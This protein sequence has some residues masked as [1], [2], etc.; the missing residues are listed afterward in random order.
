MPA[1]MTKCAIVKPSTAPT[2]KLIAGRGMIALLVASFQAAGRVLIHPISAAPAN[3]DVTASTLMRV[4]LR[5]TE[6]P[7]AVTPINSIYWHPCAMA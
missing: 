4:D 7:A 6:S 5:A 3:I 2:K 1:S